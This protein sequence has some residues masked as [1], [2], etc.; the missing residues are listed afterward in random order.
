M[1]GY[2][3]KG[4]I[5]LA[6]YA[7]GLSVVFAL[8]GLPALASDRLEAIRLPETGRFPENVTSTSDGTLFVSS[9][10]D[11][12][13]LRIG[14]GGATATAFLKPGDH[15]TRSTFGLLTDEKSGIL[16]VASNDATAIGA[17]GPTATEGAWVKAFDL[18]TGAL[19]QSVR[20]PGDRAL[21]N[22]FALD[23]QGALYVTNT[24]APQILRLKPGAAAFEVFVEDPALAKGLDGIAFGSDGNIYVNTFMGGEF[25]RIAVKDGVAGP[26]TKLETTQPLKFPDGLRAFGDS[27]LMVEGSGALSR[28]T[29]SGNWAKL[30]PLGR[31]A[32]PTGVTVA[33]GR[34]WVSEG[35]LRLLSEP[36]KDGHEAPSFHL[37]SIGID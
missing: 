21:A 34:I 13:V 32:G 27:F 4:R 37:R 28:I 33:G 29:V 1:N 2:R 12:G 14:A 22:D 9:I 5:R 19:K 35:Q 31:F 36:A 30:E 20:L 26:V 8:M 6:R 17:R 3:F 10:A 15:G 25:F 16:W 23:R 7:V 18:L 11:G 24:F